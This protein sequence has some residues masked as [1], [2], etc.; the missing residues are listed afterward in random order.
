MRSRLLIAVALLA[1]VVWGLLRN[2]GRLLVTSDPLPA[3]ADAIVVLAG[4]VADRVL[5]A[6]DL[7]AAHIA[8]QVVVTRERPPVGER[9][10][11]K[12][13]VHLPDSDAQQRAALVQLGVPAT[14]IIRLQRRA[15]STESEA[16]TIGRYA[17][18]RAFR[19]LVVVTSAAHTF[20]AGLILRQALGQN[21]ALTMRAS[22]YDPF[23]AARWWRVR[24]AAKQV[25]SEFQ[26]L[27][28]YALVE[29]WRIKPC[30][31]LRRF[32]SVRPA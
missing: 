2:A 28:D 10:L 13:G 16:N 30:G 15:Y 29:R 1:I 8:P 27:L 17:C 4:S 12:R 5:E 25:L 26:K 24:H 31:G 9:A 22:R 6:A 7:Y 18:R 3:H 21:I 23:P 19:H 14:A 20:R 32:R 11:I